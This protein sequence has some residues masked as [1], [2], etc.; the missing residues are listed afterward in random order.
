MVG[1]KEKYIGY[2]AEALQEI[3]EIASSVPKLGY[4]LGQPFSPMYLS[5]AC[6]LPK[7]TD[8]GEQTGEDGKAASG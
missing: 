3:F 4:Q 2:T 1:K 8:D 7:R 6:V 5:E